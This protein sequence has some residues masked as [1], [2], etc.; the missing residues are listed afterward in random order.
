VKKTKC[1]LLPQVVKLTESLAIL[2]SL[3][4]CEQPRQIRREP[5]MEV[6]ASVTSIIQM[7]K[8]IGGICGSYISRYRD[9]PKDLRGIVIEL[10][11]V[12]SVLEVIQ[13]LLNESA[14]TNSSLREQMAGQDGPLTA[15]LSTLQEL[16]SLFPK[17]ERIVNGERKICL[18]HLERLRWPSKASKA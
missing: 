16:S 4:D 10:G 3:R 8:T 14:G 13:L 5:A 17:E 7:A 1:D 12:K 15:C 9:A 11:S 18:E 2:N 6:A